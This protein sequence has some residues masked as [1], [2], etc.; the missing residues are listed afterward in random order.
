MSERQA[1][2]LEDDYYLVNFHTISGFVVDTYHDL[3]SSE[4]HQWVDMIRTASKPAQRLYIR[5]LTRRGSTFRR[6]RLR[7]EEIEDISAA[8]SELAE[9]GLAG[10][11]APGDWATLLGC[12]T[13]P[14][15]LNLLALS[16]LRN[17]CR[18][19]LTAHITSAEP[20]L[21]SQYREVL[22]AA[23][24][25]IT[26]DG[27]AHWMLMQ[28]CFFGNLY[29][30]SSELVLRQLGALTYE[31]YQLDPSARAFTSREHIEAHWR[32]FECA[33]LLD[34]A[35]QRDPKALL[36]VA[37]SLPQAGVHDAILRRRTDRIR[38][39][40]ARQ[41]E[42][43]S[44]LEEAMCLYKSSIHPPARERCVRILLASERWT[45]ALLLTGD[46]IDSS[47]NETEKL[48]GLKLQARCEKALGRV[49]IRN[50][51]FKP[52][53][54]KIVLRN[55][56][57]RVEELARRFYAGQGPCFHTE[58]TLVNGV[59]GL[60]IWDIIFHPLPG[61]FFNPFQMAPA[62]FH[63][64]EFCVNRAGL[65][66]T[67]F[68]ELDDRIKLGARVHEAYELHFGKL[69]P[70]VRWSHLTPDMLALAVDR[71]PMKH[72]HALFTRILADT[73]DNTAGFPDLV[74]FPEN[75]G[76]EFIEIKG[77]GDALQSNQRRWMQHFSQNGIACRLVHVRYRTSELLSD[78][79]DK[80][81]P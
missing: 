16:R 44:C 43:L 27:H 63:E 10:L 66:K 47:Y 81:A 22:Q 80:E 51:V 55:D 62:D 9:C 70:L 17:M 52:A 32:Y 57:S 56:G 23:D 14:E 76:Y 11:R 79:D 28:L 12:F 7:Y 26:L 6:S 21:Q 48:V 24:H 46:M 49:P 65:L 13:K 78:T 69:N 74:L 59:L 25:W 50:R 8:A 67:R 64:P 40:V 37:D 45:E 1:P 19:D 35:D 71:I 77:P 15:L 34:C 39:R 75:G 5:L 73:R 38:N 20:A 2:D 68:L 54:K 29:Q 4:E 58:N 53:T 30:D 3:L 41:L 60:F 42:R 61:V 33:T 18:V 36:S 72:W 31:D